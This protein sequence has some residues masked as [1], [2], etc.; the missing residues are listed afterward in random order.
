MGRDIDQLHFR[1]HD[2]QLFGHRFKHEMELLAEWF[3]TEHFSQRHSIAGLELEAW[4]VDQRGQPTPWN[5]EVIRQ[6]GLAD[7]VPE[8]ARYNI[9]FNTSPQ[10]I[11]G[12][13]LARMVQ[14]LGHSWRSCDIAA[15]E[16]GTSVVSIGLLPTLRDSM[17]T[18][19]R[20]TQS[21]RYRALNEQVLRLRQGR[22]IL[23]QLHG[24]Q[25]VV[26]EHRD[27]MLES[28]TTSLQLHL[29]VPLER[30]V[31]M[32][33]A[34]VIVSAPMV[35][36]TANS[37]FLF[38]HD[39]W[40]ETRI[41]LFE[42]SLD[43]GT[44]TAKRVTFG[45][46]YARES[47]EEIF[48]ENAQLHPVLLPMV[49]SEDTQDMSHVR[50]HNGTI[51]RWNRPLLGF[52]EDGT[53]H[54]R[55]EHR[56]M[57][58]GPT[59]VDM[60]ANMAFYYGL[61]ESL[62]G[63]STPP[64]QLL[65][66]AC[67][68]DNF[69]KAAQFGLSADVTWLSGRTIP[70]SELILNELLP[71]A[72]QGLASLGTES[73]WGAKHLEI[74]RQRVTS[75][76]TGTTWQRNYVKAHGPDFEGL[77][78]QYRENQQ[79]GQ[80][81]HTWK[82]QNSRLAAAVIS[83]VPESMLS[84]TD[85]L[86]TGLLTA[87][88]RELRALLE[89]PTLVHLPGRRSERLFVSV[90]LHGNEDV[91]LLALQKLLSQYQTRELPRAMSVFIGNVWAAEANVR[92]LETQPD[93]NRVWPNST[94]D[95]LP[96]HAL[97]RHVVR[98]MRQ[99]TLFA[100][101]DLH[102]NTGWNPHYSCIRKLDRRHLQLARLFGRNAVYFHYPVGVQTGA[103]CDLC[104]SLTCE[105]G[106]IGDEAG[107]QHAAEFLDA[108]L[109]IGE[110]PDLSLSPGDLRLYHSVASLRVANR[111]EICIADLQH[112]TS[113]TNQLLLRSDIDH[114]NFRELQSGEILGRILPGEA[115]P[116]VVQDQNGNDIT[117]EFIQVDMGTILL[118]RTVIPSMLTCNTDVIRQDCLGYFMEPLTLKN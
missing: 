19:S 31:R 107:V 11:S 47:L 97:M 10:P 20:M 102:N 4:L 117:E 92:F 83:P 104:P 36:V 63:Q 14:H 51:W 55:I 66:F 78:Q 118:K 18:Q 93:Y 59:L 15:R 75:G 37:P 7:V 106:R 60:A 33:N 39:F 114:L 101:I 84:I 111:V 61:V 108:C 41:A 99:H 25:S 96:E 49:T 74:I 5:K 13:G 54:L 79:W 64:E 86:P 73:N 76:Q 71:L 57:A 24:R 45:N 81:V 95:D 70:L 46:D 87:S 62:G 65:S 38:G 116:M 68:R 82:T 56:V 98:L 42:Q 103:F 115:L 43:L 40:D 22:P 112:T 32:Y 80:P 58:A 67:A 53:P 100:S 35:A 27:V 105:C 26:S 77:V 52:D 28:A 2:H 91:G 50:L 8:L 16:L 21:D 17:L 12:D 3:R 94:L 44:E 6:A 69:Y 113:R 34:A 85:K 48:I 72:E 89:R 30:S 88:P 23:L 110:L 109:H 29:Q 9:E 1:Q 90:M